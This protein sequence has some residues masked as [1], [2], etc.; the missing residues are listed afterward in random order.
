MKCLVPLDNVVEEV[1]VLKDCLLVDESSL[2]AWVV[3]EGEYL[4][5]L[6]RGDVDVILGEGVD[7]FGFI[8]LSLSFICNKNI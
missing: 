6:Q 8:S 5:L 3:V 7:G 1:V 4:D 2:T